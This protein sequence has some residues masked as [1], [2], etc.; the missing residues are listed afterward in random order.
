MSDSQF[1]VLFSQS[2]RFEHVRNEVIKGCTPS[3][4]SLDP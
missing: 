3:N 4:N 2:K 1:E